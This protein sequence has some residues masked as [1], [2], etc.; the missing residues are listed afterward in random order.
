MRT[1]YLTIHFYDQDVN[2][3][4]AK[5]L[6]LPSIRGTVLPCFDWQVNN[7]GIAINWLWVRVKLKWKN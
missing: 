3:N 5:K 4:K 7:S 1:K 2:V 6:Y